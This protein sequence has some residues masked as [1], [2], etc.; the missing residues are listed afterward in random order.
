MSQIHKNERAKSDLECLHV[1][2]QLRAKLRTTLM[3]SFGF[4]KKRLKEMVY[5]E[6]RFISD[7]TGRE[8]AQQKLTSRYMHY[9][10]WLMNNDR[11]RLLNQLNDLI[12]HIVAANNIHPYYKVD[13]NERRLEWDRAIESVNDLQQNLQ[14][15][16]ETLPCD[17]N[18]YMSMVDD[19]DHIYKMIKKIRQYDNKMYPHLKDVKAFGDF[20]TQLT[21]KLDTIIDI[22]GN[23]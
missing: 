14:Y 6:T 18:K 19:L 8:I 10:N 13:Y 1:A 15:I 7:K 9:Y 5:K 2:Y 21:S 23:M 12:D 20:R 4:S 16:G 22:L 3:L 17:K 11:T